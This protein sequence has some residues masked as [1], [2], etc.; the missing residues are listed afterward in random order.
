M[1]QR[2]TSASTHRRSSDAIVGPVRTCV[3]CRKRELA[4][5][6]L[7]V[8]AVDDGNEPGNGASAVTV[9]S[10][11]RLPG[12]GA[13]LHPDPQCL[14]VAIRRRAFGRALRITGSPDLTAVIEY[15]SAASSAEPADPP[16]NRTGSEEHEHTVK[17]R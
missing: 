1:I 11:R 4:V 12:R 7:R 8:V 13:W 10:A 6:L 15:V 2:E 16:G 17:P 14:E 3:G 5:E 9:D